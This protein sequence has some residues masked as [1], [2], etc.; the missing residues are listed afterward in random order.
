[1]NLAATLKSYRDELAEVAS[2]SP[3]IVFLCGPSLSGTDAPAQLRRTIKERLEAEKFEVVLGED[4]GL[5]NPDIHEIGINAQDNE[6]A[7]IGSHCNAVV[8]IASS[9]GSF[10]ELALFSWHLVHE[11]GEID[12]GKTDCIVLISNEFE[13]HKS[14]LNSGPAKA[15]RSFGKVEFINFSLTTVVNSLNVCETGAVS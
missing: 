14:Y 10:C 9:A 15:A 1:M 12:S 6:L 11:H 4:D 8:I 5:D 7:F 3:F 13:S 2:S